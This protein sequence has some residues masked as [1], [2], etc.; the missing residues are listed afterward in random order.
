M[1]FLMLT[2]CILQT[3][4]ASDLRVVLK[5][6]AAEDTHI[7][8]SATLINKVSEFYISLPPYSALDEF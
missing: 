8:S 3:R 5:I 1:T 4:S 7:K 6:Y 2:K